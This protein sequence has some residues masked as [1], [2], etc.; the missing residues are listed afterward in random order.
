MGIVLMALN[1]DWPI[2]FADGTAAWLDEDEPRLGDMLQVC[3]AEKPFGVP[4]AP[5]AKKRGLF[6]LLV[7][8]SGDHRLHNVAMPELRF[9][10]GSEPTSASFAKSGRAVRI[11]PG[12]AERLYSWPALKP[13]GSAPEL[14]VMNRAAM[15]REE[16]AAA[17]QAE[18]ESNDLFGMF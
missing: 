12:D 13:L 18:L 16:K 14:I 17:E 3:T 4:M 11:Y 8:A 5:H 10:D 7:E 15:E 1:W 6:A 9:P 2:E